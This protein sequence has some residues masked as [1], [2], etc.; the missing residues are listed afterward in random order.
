ME[1]LT[2]KIG[3][4]SPKMESLA[5]KSWEPGPKNGEPGVRFNL[6]LRKNWPRGAEFHSENWPRVMKK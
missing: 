2:P 4:P 6:A 3:N 5:P 1:N